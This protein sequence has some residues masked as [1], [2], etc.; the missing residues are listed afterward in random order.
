MPIRLNRNTGNLHNVSPR[1]YDP[2]G[3]VPHPLQSINIVSPG[4]ALN[5]NHVSGAKYVGPLMIP[6]HE[7]FLAYNFPR[8]GG[9]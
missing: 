6:G 9:T 5:P 7:M 3:F 4:G 1:L 8:R 2:A